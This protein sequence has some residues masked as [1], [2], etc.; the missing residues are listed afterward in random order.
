M[1]RGNYRHGGRHT[2]LYTI[3]KDMRQ[4]CKN[5]NGSRRKSYYDKGIKVCEEWESFASFRAW[6]IENGYSDEL[7]I[8]RI[9]TNGNYEP[10]NCRWATIEVQQNNRTTNRFIEYNGESHT[11]AEWSRIKGIKSGTLWARLHS[12]WEVERALTP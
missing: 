6:A 7:S 2:R 3:W 12:G 11:I 9:D 10:G 1:S 8:D 5:P 4:R